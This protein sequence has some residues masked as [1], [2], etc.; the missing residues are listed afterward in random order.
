MQILQVA[1]LQRVVLWRRFTVALWP[2]LKYTA[3]FMVVRFLPLPSVCAFC[4]P[5]GQWLPR[6]TGVA[7]REGCFN[8]RPAFAVMTCQLL[9]LG[10]CQ[11]R[12]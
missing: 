7:Q 1:K 4:S 9:L 11:V 3:P 12:V 2:A 8:D 5:V 10:I 6:C